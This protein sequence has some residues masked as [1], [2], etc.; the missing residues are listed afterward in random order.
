MPGR[1]SVDELISD[2]GAALKC[3]NAIPSID[4]YLFPPYYSDL[5]LLEKLA[6]TLSEYSRRQSTS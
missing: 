6:T 3:S 4:T 1:E 5:I 2:F